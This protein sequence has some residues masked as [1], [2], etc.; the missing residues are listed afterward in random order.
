[1]FQFYYL[2]IRSLQVGI[3]LKGG[4]ESFFREKGEVTFASCAPPQ[5]TYMLLFLAELWGLVY[6]CDKKDF[7]TNQFTSL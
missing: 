2:H 4:N 7:K 6:S 5:H 3:F 1:M